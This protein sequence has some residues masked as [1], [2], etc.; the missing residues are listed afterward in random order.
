MLRDTIVQLSEQSEKRVLAVYRLYVAGKLS[1]DETATAIANII[2]AANGQAG[3]VADLAMTSEVF[4]QIGEPV[5]VAT[6]RV[7][8]DTSRLTEAAQTALE[9]AEASE[10]PEAIIARLG[11]CEPL[12]RAA[13]SYSDAMVR[14][15]RTKGWVRDRSAN[16]CELCEWWWRN[17]RIWPAE[18]PF[19][20]H[21]GCTCTPKP[22]VARNIRETGYTAHTK[23]IR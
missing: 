2:A 22:V 16:C 23:G 15:G 12:E 9:V 8:D 5:P 17:G 19:Q 3:A 14:T 7:P 10:V 18:H 13:A 4:A 6:G 1:R 21:K 11:R 20:H